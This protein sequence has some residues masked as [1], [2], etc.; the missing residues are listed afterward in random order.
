[1]ETRENLASLMI[2]K[3]KLWE[4]WDRREEDTWGSVSSSQ[5][6]FGAVGVNGKWNDGKKPAEKIG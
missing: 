2:L 1:M 3:Q 5:Q 6:E 4:E